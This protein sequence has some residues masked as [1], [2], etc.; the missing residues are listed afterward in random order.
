MKNLGA[1]TTETKADADKALTAMN[2]LSTRLTEV[3]QKM[4]RRGNGDVPPELKSLGQHVVDDAGV[5]SLM[6]QKNGQARITVELKD[7]FSG[8]GAVGHGRVADQRADHSRPPADG[9]A[10]WRNLVV[11]DLL[12]PGTT[13]SNAIEYP[14]ETDNPMTTGAAVVSEGALKPQSNITFDLKSL[15][16]RTIAHWMKAPR[17]IMDDVP[18]LQSYIDGR[19]RYGLEYVEENELLYGDGTGQHLLGIIPQ[20]TAYTAA[21]APTAPQAIDTLRLAALQATLRSTRRP[22]M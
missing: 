13:R 9:A 11:R 3:E 5:K 1:A 12:T 8:P 19:L 4:S 21:F 22:D 6:E 14:V 17:Q 10:A 18:Q 20:A 16:V 7:I 15:P 2:E